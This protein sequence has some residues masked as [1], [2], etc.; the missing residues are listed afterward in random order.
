MKKL[1]VI[2]FIL[3]PFGAIADNNINVFELNY[4]LNIQKDLKITWGGKFLT[5][6]KSKLSDL[7]YKVDYS[8][9]IKGDTSLVYGMDG[10]D[11]QSNIKVGFGV[12][13]NNTKAAFSFSQKISK[14]PGVPA[15]GV[16]MRLDVESNF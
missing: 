3:L 12:A 9:P 8:L 15:E 16:V 4:K 13:S 10:T 1:L 2:L 5:E 14:D 11:T 7:K 6:E